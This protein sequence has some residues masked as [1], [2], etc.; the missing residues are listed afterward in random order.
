MVNVF[1]L[2]QAVAFAAVAAALPLA[3]LPL[4]Q[5]STSG[6]NSNTNAPSAIKAALAGA[7]SYND[8]QAILFANPPDA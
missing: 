7:A 2:V 8:R 1:S 3:Q 5:Y 4:A 6:F